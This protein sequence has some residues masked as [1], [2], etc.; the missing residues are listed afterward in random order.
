MIRILIAE[1]LN[2]TY[3]LLIS[4]I[5]I[6]RNEIIYPHH[7]YYVSLIS[8]NRSTV[9][10]HCTSRFFTYIADITMHRKRYKITS[11]TTIERSVFENTPEEERQRTTV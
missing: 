5:T 7:L 1:A 4:Y 6:M 11:E 8:L 3:A 2:I 10:Y 9:S